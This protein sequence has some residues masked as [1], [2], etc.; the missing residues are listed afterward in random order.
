MLVSLVEMKFI[1]IFFVVVVVFFSGQDLLAEPKLVLNWL[2]GWI[3][4][5]GSVATFPVLGLQVWVTTQ[6]IQHS[7]HISHTLYQFS[8][9]EWKKKQKG[10]H[11]GF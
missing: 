6:F 2:C 5:S 8:Y 4:I 1:K 9:I 3:N 11:D 10:G 7:G